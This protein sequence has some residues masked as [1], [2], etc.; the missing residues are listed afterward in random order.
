MKI[1]RILGILV[2]IGLVLFALIQLIPCGRSHKN[3]PV[4]QE[5]NWDAQTRL[6]A[7]KAC[8]G[9]HSNETL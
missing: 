1:V 4:V 6:I 2:L 3:P 8:I 9:C 7:K 5:P